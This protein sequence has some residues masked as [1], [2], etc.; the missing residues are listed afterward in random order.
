MR[1]FDKD[2]AARRPGHVRFTQAKTAE[3]MLLHRQC[4]GSH[5]REAADAAA[6]LAGL[7]PVACLVETPPVAPQF[8]EPPSG[9]EAEGDRQTLLAVRSSG[10]DRV[11]MAP[12]QILRSRYR[13]LKIGEQQDARLASR[14]YEPSVGQILDG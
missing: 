7:H 14:Q 5:G 3:E 6:K 2:V 9:F 11:A 4:A 13:S 1:P 8:G 10:H 12:A